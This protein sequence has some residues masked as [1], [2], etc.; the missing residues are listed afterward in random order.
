MEEKFIWLGEGLVNGGDSEFNFRYFK[1]ECMRFFRGEE[2]I[3]LNFRGEG[4]G[5]EM[6]FI[7]S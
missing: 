1:F 6:F 5:V 2:Y 3:D 7:L 4:L